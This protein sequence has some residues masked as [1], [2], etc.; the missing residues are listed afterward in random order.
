MINKFVFLVIKYFK[1]AEFANEAVV[2]EE[3]FRSCEP[4]SYDKDFGCCCP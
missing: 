3:S 4:A 1:P 2:K